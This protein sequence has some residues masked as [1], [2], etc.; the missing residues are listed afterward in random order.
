MDKFIRVLHYDD[1]SH[2]AAMKLAK[3]AGYDIGKAARDWLS[4]HVNVDDKRIQRAEYS[5]QVGFDND[6]V[7]YSPEE[8]RQFLLSEIE[9][10]VEPMT[11]SEM[12]ELALNN[13]NM[14]IKENSSTMHYRVIG[15]DTVAS[16]VC[17]IYRTAYEWKLVKDIRA[18]FTYSLD[19]GQTW[20]RFEHRPNGLEGSLCHS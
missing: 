7:T 3:Q 19:N 14:L 12:I 5:M 20:H 10:Q 1:A 13:P 11:I 6:T 4:W 16:E 2:K 8:L 9:S 18:N 17:A 15:I